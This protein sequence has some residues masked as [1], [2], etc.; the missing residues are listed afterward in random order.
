MVVAPSDDKRFKAGWTLVL[1]NLQAI[2]RLA[3]QHDIEV[4]LLVQPFTFQLFAEALQRLQKILLQHAL[5]HA[6]QHGI[7]A[8]DL[9]RVYEEAI[10]IDI[11]EIL[12]GLQQG[13]DM[14]QEDVDLLA[15]F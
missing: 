10:R 2:Y 7:D 5:E 13:D 11:E 9:T 8:I 3:P 14:A 6:L 12:L 1:E 15:A 4:V